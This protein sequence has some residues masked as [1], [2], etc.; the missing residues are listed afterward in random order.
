MIR[1]SM[2]AAAAL[3]ALNVS[4]A[5]AQEHQHGAPAEAQ[6]D[7]AGM[8]Q[9]QSQMMQMMQMMQ[10]GMMGGGMMGGSMMTGMAQPMHPQ[11][12]ALLRASD[13]IGLSTEQRERLEALSQ[14]AEREVRQHMQAA[15]AAHEQARSALGGTRPDLEAYATAMREAAEHMVK[16]HV[17]M[18]RTSAEAV[19]L[20]TPAQREKLSG[21]MDFMRAMAGG[22]MGGDMMG[23]SGM[24]R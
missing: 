6:A 8:M 12:G 2:L 3:V 4:P 11:P 16:G 9:M 17:E 22:M 23:G 14:Q 20:L 21:A 13:A 24:E 5:L 15:M 7:A 18:V 1:N 10:E 19:A